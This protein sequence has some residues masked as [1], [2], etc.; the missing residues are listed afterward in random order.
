VKL[1]LQ[2][3]S[4]TWPGGPEQIGPT[5]ARIART[6]DEAVL[7]QIFRDHVLGNDLRVL[8]VR[9]SENLPWRPRTRCRSVP[10]AAGDGVFRKARARDHPARDRIDRV[11][12]QS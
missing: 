11:V 2:I 12:D 5:L 3:P 4:F 9:E 8:L 6:A 10:L 7:A 1:G